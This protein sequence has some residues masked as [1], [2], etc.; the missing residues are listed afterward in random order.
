MISFNE[1]INQK[2]NVDATQITSVYNKAHIAVDL[3]RWYNP[4]ILDNISTIAN[5]ASGAYG[6]Y[7]SGENKKI[8]PPDVQQSLIYYGKLNP[9]SIGNIPKKTLMQ[10]YPQIDKNK[11]QQSD[12]IRVNVRRILNEK[13]TDIE[14]VLEIAS[15]IVHEATH[16]IERETTGQTS[17]IGPEQAEKTFVQWATKNMQTIMQKYPELSGS[18]GQFA[19]QI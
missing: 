19:T 2:Q 16:E 5:L 15:T 18:I 13:K 8:I 9:Q 10:Y 4:Q 12:T 14:A 11:I 7:N 3:V 6:V 1:F 17:E